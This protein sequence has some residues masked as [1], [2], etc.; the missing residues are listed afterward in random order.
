VHLQV[1]AVAADCRVAIDTDAHA[2]HELAF[3]E[4]GLAA[5]IR[6]GI[7]RERVVNFLPREEL[8]AWA[9]APRAAVSHSV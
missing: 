5:A 6:A 1:A 7:R 2:P 4:F 9:R 3:V 8:L